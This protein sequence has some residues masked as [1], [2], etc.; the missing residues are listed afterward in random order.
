MSA[1]K[2][3]KAST[4]QEPNCKE[5]HRYT[6]GF[7]HL[8]RSSAAAAAEQAV[9]QAAKQAV[10]DA[11]QAGVFQKQMQAEKDAEKARVWEADQRARQAASESKKQ[12]KCNNFSGRNATATSVSEMPGPLARPRVPTD[13]GPLGKAAMRFSQTAPP[14]PP[15]PK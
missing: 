3:V 14:Q 1:R 15:K 10:D 12:E 5:V 4:C 8:H 7:C 13:H 9:K 2:S 6:D 11:E